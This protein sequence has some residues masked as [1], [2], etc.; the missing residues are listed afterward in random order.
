[1]S[2]LLYGTS[3]LVGAPG[4]ELDRIVTG[5][6]HDPHSVLGAHPARD[7]DGRDV[8]VIR[9]WRPDAVDMAIVL[10][11]ERI[12]MRPLHPAGLFGGVVAG[13]R[14]PDYRL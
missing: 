5:E 3:E 9:G 4:S 12:A 2:G 11:G 13:T 1:M 6:H 8:V 14:I 10:D 7:A